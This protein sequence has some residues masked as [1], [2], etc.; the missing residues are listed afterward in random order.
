M[1][2]LIEREDVIITEGVMVFRIIS[3]CSGI[4]LCSNEYKSGL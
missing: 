3:H 1:N 4:V 2:S